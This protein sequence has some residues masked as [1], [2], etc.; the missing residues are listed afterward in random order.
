MGDSRDADSD[1]GRERFA[2]IAAAFGLLVL[3]PGLAVISFH[4]FDG[5]YGQDAFSYVEYAMG[6]VRTA[7]AH[8]QPLPAFF[9]PP[10]YPLV[11]ALVASPGLGERS[12]Q[13]VSLV[14]GTAVPIVTAF[15][16]REVLLPRYNP[17]RRDALAL[18]AGGAAGIAGQLWQSSV[19]AMSDTT[20]VAF[21]TIGAWA[22]CRFYNRGGWLPL[23]ASAAAFG[24]ALQ[25]RWIYG[26]VAL[27]FVVLALASLAREARVSWHRATIPFLAATVAS[28]VVLLPTALPMLSAVAN[29]QPLPFVG[30]FNVYHWNP[31]GGLATTFE[32]VDGRLAYALPTAVFYFIQ[33]IEPYWLALLGLLVVPGLL[34]V[35]RHPDE[36]SALALIA[37]PALVIGFH[38]GGAYQ[39]ARFFLAALPPVAVLVSIGAATLSTYTARSGW[40]IKGIA[41]S[42]L[43][44]AGVAI[45]VVV[46]A[47]LA[48]RYTNGFVERQTAD[49]G[50]IR[51]LTGMVPPG[52]RI[53]SLGATTVLHH[54]GRDV[55]ELFSLEPD[56][57]YSLLSD[58]RPS[59]L[60]I[61]ANAIHTQF[62]EVGAGRTVAAL[63]QDPGVSQVG[64][65]GIWTLYRVGCP[66]PTIRC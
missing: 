28:L 5:L 10:G 49:L 64:A 36:L 38:M 27:P 34:T 45:A 32:T 52:S 14:A 44:I 61:D 53:L 17:R 25:V 54:D 66:T 16:A 60:L 39:N 26:L 56:A 58:G 22:C 35:I 4:G 48:L 15:F 51:T 18:L 6:S 2:L 57:A 41:G 33:P 12:G 50:A 1:R 9:W 46:S 23:A 40:R 31:L 29:S 65:A 19:V 30:D 11:V 21:A 24:F 42:R 47:L 43:L 55:V 7:L 13:I 63:E 62:A 59:Y 8:L 37:W 3:V 20:A